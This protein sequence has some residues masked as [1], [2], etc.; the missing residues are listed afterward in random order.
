MHAKTETGRLLHDDHARTI[1]ILNRLEDFLERTDG[2]E[3]VPGTDGDAATLIN[4]LHRFLCDEI[5]QHFDFEEQKVFPVLAQ[6]GAHELAA[7][8]TGE[9]AAMRLLAKRL[10]H[11][12]VLTI[13]K[14]FDAD[15]WLVFRFLSEN[16]SERMFFH[17]QQEETAL[18]G[19]VESTLSPET[20]RL[21]AGT[22]DGSVR[23]APGF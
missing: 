8:L 2:T 6:A 10:Q 19:I 18:L 21:I 4:A 15:S 5:D 23:T 7:I 13:Q 16:L 1:D 11:L 22:R 17:L 12:C 3:T 9:H 20:D 14:G